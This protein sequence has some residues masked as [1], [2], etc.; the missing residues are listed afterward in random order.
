LAS[1]QPTI[2]QDYI[3]TTVIDHTLT[4]STAILTLLKS[5]AARIPHAG[6]LSDVLGATLALLGI[7]KQ[8]RGSRDDCNYLIERFL[9]LFNYLLEDL[10]Q[11]STRIEDDTTA[12]RVLQLLR[13]VVIGWV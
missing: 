11:T 8:M 7:V 1:K 2:Y 10:E 9:L 4:E 13:C 5:I 6:P 12:G 3:R